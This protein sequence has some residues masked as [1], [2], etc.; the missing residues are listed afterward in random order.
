MFEYKLKFQTQSLTQTRMYL[1]V[2]H[3]PLPVQSPIKKLPPEIVDHLDNSPVNA[4]Q[5]QEWTRRDPQL[6]QI[7]K[8]VQPS[9]IQTSLPHFLRRKQG[10]QF[11]KVVVYYGVLG[12][13][14]FMPSEMLY[15]LN[16][17]KIIQGSREWRDSLGCTCGGLVSPRISNGLYN[18]V[19]HVSCTKPHC[20]LPYCTHGVGRGYAYSSIMPDRYEERWYLSWSM[21]VD[22]GCLHSECCHNWGSE[23]NIC[24]IWNSRDHRLW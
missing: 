7:L 16:F 2:S 3:Y 20:Q 17:M 12:S 1:V 13:S 24:T 18:N 5:I 10:S 23:N 11:T 14:S 22:W 4:H 9:Q 15:S 6:A 19:L 21:L 8:F